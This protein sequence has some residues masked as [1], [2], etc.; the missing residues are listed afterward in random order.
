MSAVEDLRRTVARLRAPGGCPWDIEQTHQ[1]L[2]V[3]LIEECAEL[4]DTIDRL[5]MEH[6]RDQATH[7]AIAR[8]LLGHTRDELTALAQS[9]DIPLHTLR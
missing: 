5:D 1:S 4:L 6:M 8:F 3:C 7:A 2:A 9:R